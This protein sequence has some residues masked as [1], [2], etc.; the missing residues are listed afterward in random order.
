VSQGWLMTACDSWWWAALLSSTCHRAASLNS[1]IVG[2]YTMNAGK[3]RKYFPENQLNI[4]QNITEWKRLRKTGVT[5]TWRWFIRCIKMKNKNISQI[6]WLY[7]LGNWVDLCT[8]RICIKWDLLG[9]WHCSKYPAPWNLHS[10][11]M[12]PYPRQEIWGHERYI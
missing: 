10:S 1:T 7:Y 2:K 5:A 11:N 9:A 12:V 6:T 8:H 4:Y 3:C